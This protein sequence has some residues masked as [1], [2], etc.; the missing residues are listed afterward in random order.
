MQRPDIK[1]I[2]VAS[3]AISKCQTEQPQRRFLKNNAVVNSAIH[4]S[5]PAVAKLRFLRVSVAPRPELPA[6]VKYAESTSKATPL[7]QRRRWTAL[8]VWQCCG[9][10][11]TRNW[12]DYSPK[13]PDSSEGTLQTIFPQPVFRASP[14]LDA[15]RPVCRRLGSKSY[16]QG[17]SPSRLF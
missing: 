4:T 3:D 2:A 12:F 10:D 1:R 6:S 8:A 17:R 14:A 9:N 13:R 5:R 11:A 16:H 7:R 15:I